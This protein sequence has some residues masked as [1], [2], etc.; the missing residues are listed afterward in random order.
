MDEV[1]EAASKMAK[2][3]KRK[4][5]SERCSIEKLAAALSARASAMWRSSGSNEKKIIKTRNSVCHRGGIALA[6]R[7]Q[8]GAE[9][10]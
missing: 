5:D 10:A 3:K 9:T 6:E 2:K 4:T 1:G 8:L 7:K